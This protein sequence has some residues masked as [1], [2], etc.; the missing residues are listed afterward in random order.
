MN[1]KKQISYST[2]NLNIFIRKRVVCLSTSTN[3][4]IP[5]FSMEIMTTKLFTEIEKK[6]VS[7]YMENGKA[8]LQKGIENFGYKDAEDIAIKAT[9]EGDIHTLFDYIPKDHNKQNKYENLTPFALFAKLFA[10]ITKAVVDAYGDEGEKVVEDAVREFGEKRGH[11]IA[12]RARVNGA[13][14]TINQYLTNYDM[15]RSELFT[16]DTVYKPEEIEQS[17]TVCPLGDQWADDEMHKYGLVYCRVID[18]AIAHGYN[19]KF[20]VVHDQFL[21]K[22][23]QCHFRFQLKDEEEKND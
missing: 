7:K 9:T 13:N 4:F 20:N 18:D 16:M 14:N 6:V 12:Q 23:G 10:Q 15:G 21:L 2:D 8:L 11:G 3:H 22:E 17:F 19:D 5:P 1:F